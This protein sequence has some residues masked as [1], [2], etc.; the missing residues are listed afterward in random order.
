MTV[1]LQ[2][3]IAGLALVILAPLVALIGKRYGRKAKGG[4]VLASILL[5]IGHPIDPPPRARIEDA[6]PSKGERPKG[7]PPLKD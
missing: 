1:W 7:E 5:G 3:V 6:E 2:F 4:L